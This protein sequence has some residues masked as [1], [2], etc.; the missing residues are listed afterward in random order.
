MHEPGQLENRVRAI[1]AKQFE[2][3]P[4]EPLDNLGMGNPPAWDSMGHMEL[5]VTIEDDFGV[6]FPAH[7]IAT[8]TTVQA[9]VE[10]L[11]AQHAS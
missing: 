8:L 1:I 2:L 11:R 6:R 5:L 10:A 7:S 4:S 9:I 3:S